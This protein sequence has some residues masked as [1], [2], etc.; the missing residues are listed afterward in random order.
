MISTWLNDIYL[1]IQKVVPGGGQL[2]FSVASNSA[3][4]AVISF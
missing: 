4:I 2:D 1:I 3:L